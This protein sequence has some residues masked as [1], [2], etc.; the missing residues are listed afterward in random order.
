[1][2]D[3]VKKH[4]VKSWSFIAKQLQGRLGKQCRERWYNHLNPSINKHPWTPEEDRLIIEEHGYKGNK[5]AEIAKMLYGRTDNA[6]KNR[7]NSTLQRLIKQ[8]CARIDLN[9]LSS[10]D[11]D[12]KADESFFIDENGDE[13]PRS[14]SKPTTA[15]GGDAKGSNGNKVR[16]RTLSAAQAQELNIL[17]NNHHR[18]AA[19][20]SGNSAGSTLSPL[21]SPGPGGATGNF[22]DISTPVGKDG[23]AKLLGGKAKKSRRAGTPDSASGGAAGVGE[24]EEDEGRSG[25]SKRR[26]SPMKEPKAPRSA[27]KSPKKPL[28]GIIEGDE[29]SGLGI[30][31]GDENP[32][33][34]SMLMLL[35]QAALE[36][37][38]SPE[39]EGNAAKRKRMAKAKSPR[40]GAEAREEYEVEGCNVLTLTPPLSPPRSKPLTEIDGAAVGQLLHFAVSVLGSEDGGGATSSS[41]ASASANA[42]V[43]AFSAG[44]AAES[45]TFEGS[46]VGASVGTAEATT[47]SAPCAAPPLSPTRTT[48]AGIHSAGIATLSPI[49]EGEPL[50]CASPL[51][52]LLSGS[53]SILRCK[54]KRAGPKSPVVSI[55]INN[56]SYTA[57]S[58]GTGT[59]TETVTGIVGMPEMVTC[60]DRDSEERPVSILDVVADVSP[61]RANTGDVAGSG[62]LTLT[63]KA[64]PPTAAGGGVAVSV[65]VSVTS[66]FQ[67]KAPNLIPLTTLLDFP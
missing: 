5:W 36:G 7:W 13:V 55:N 65:Q 63:E 25:P 58:A 56:C 47:A 8:S 17:I 16:V 18:S 30:D 38:T 20:V 43:A 41:S 54:K 40:S 12:D 26:R 3:L 45:K 14:A 66:P 49:R 67:D 37:T 4:G 34:N 21:A 27:S 2:I 19:N 53:P 28:Y 57:K 24:D 61:S 62:K 1:V 52:P 39:D 42:M 33:N 64:M 9:E 22:C 35:T 11:E 59:G 15:K 10:E 31:M 32:N 23:A 29:G 50:G 48:A 44:V 6:I 60:T 46:A 51:S